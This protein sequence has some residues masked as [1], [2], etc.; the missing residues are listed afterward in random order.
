LFVVTIA[1][2]GCSNVPSSATRIKHITSTATQ[3]GWKSHIIEGEQLD[4]LA[5]LPPQAPPKGLLTIYIEGDGYAWK[6]RFEVSDNPTPVKAIAL[7]LAL[8]HPGAVYLS[9]PC[10]SITGPI[11]TPTLWTKARFSE[12]VINASNKAI[13]KLKARYQAKN[14]QLIGYSGG[15]AV[16][17]LIAARRKDVKRLVTVAGNLDH[18][19]WTRLHGVSPLSDSLNPADFRQSLETISQY[20]F[21]GQKDRIVPAQLAQEFVAE[22]SLTADITLHIVADFDHHCCWQTQWQSL[23]TELDSTRPTLQ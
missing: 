1:V 22:F 13:D 3:Q 15:G 16:A 19:R 12:T 10:Q 4:L 9:R 2:T 21:V 11:C 7:E 17:A 8:Q 18:S 14:I 5:F 20:H 6:S 23:M